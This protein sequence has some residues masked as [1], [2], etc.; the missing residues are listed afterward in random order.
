MRISFLTVLVYTLY[1]RYRGEGS[2]V[3]YH[4]QSFYFFL[5]MASLKG[6]DSHFH[7]HCTHQLIRRLLK[8]TII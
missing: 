8:N 5:R 7:Q 1:I 4:L 3:V 6:S 2:S